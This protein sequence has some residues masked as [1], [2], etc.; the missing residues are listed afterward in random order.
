MKT[1]VLNNYLQNGTDVREEYFLNQLGRVNAVTK[2]C[3]A[4][5]YSEVFQEHSTPFTIKYACSG[6]G[7]YELDNMTVTSSPTNLVIIPPGKLYSSFV[8]SEEKSVCL[9][10]FFSES[11]IRDLFNPSIFI[12]NHQEVGIRDFLDQKKIITV[13]GNLSTIL[14]QINYTIES[15]NT[16][17]DELLILMSELVLSVFNRY[18]E[19]WKGVLAYDAVKCSTKVEISKRL[20]RVIDFIECNFREEIDIEQLANVA[21]LNQYYLIRKF[22]SFFGI[23]PYQMVLNKRMQNAKEQIVKTDDPITSIALRVGFNNLPNF[24]SAFKEN[25][26]V[27]PT[28]I[29]S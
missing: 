24:Y 27:K 11:F 10:F 7:Y 29:R 26:G 22:K 1:L 17:Q 21:F 16:A 5:G 23:T 18:E 19:T 25:F 12:E 14:N 20:Y 4:K 13:S 2:I 28:A 6:L 8:D 9:N 15:E 3:T